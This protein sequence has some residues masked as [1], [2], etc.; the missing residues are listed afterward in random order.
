MTVSSAGSLSLVG[1]ALALDFA[2]TAGGRDTAEPIEHLRSATHVVDWA[3]HAGGIDAETAER[4]RAAIARDAA[5]AQKVLRQALQLRE[6][7]YG[8]GS[9]IARGEAPPR[10]ELRTLK[11]FA[12]GALGP[13]D[14]A[15]IPGGGYA[16]DF[17]AAPAH[18][19]L[20]GPVAWSALDLLSTGNLER[21][22]QC[23]GHDCG[24]LFFDHSKNN[25]RRWCDM[26]TC[27]NRTKARRHRLTR[28]RSA[29]AHQYNGRR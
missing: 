21:L 26:A 27:G 24:W 7:I 19:A 29:A 9:A 23:P 3:T 22:K 28:S 8:I 12:G 16:F 4:S 17:S 15:P 13:A 5:A 18:I 2:N 10:A 11:E 14:L 25:S 1:G 6:A 20:L